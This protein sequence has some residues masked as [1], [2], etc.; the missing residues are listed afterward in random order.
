M[1]Y[2]TKERNPVLQNLKLTGAVSMIKFAVLHK[3]MGYGI[4]T[5]IQFS[6]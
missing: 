4:S 5:D 2:S 3:T 6:Y 1:T